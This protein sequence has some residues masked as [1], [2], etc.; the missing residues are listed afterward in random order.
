MKYSI[1]VTANNSGTVT[2]GSYAIFSFN[3]MLAYSKNYRLTKLGITQK[4]LGETLGYSASHVSLAERKPNEVSLAYWFRFAEK[5][6]G[7][8]IGTPT[9]S[10]LKK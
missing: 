7:K 4:Q 10:C 9:F 1:D 2:D 6:L 5:F 8:D 3:D